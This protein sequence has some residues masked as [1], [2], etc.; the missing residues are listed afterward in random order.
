MY[1][2]RDIE[3]RS[4]NHCCREKSIIITYSESAC[5]LSYAARK[6]HATY[7]HLWPVWLYHIFPRYLTNGTIFGKKVPNTKCVF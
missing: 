2:Q 4:R 6:A 7:C 3:A 5:S 1:V